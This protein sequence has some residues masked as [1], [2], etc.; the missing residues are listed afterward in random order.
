MKTRTVKI[1][2]LGL[3]SLGISAQQKVSKTKQSISVNKEVTIDLNTSYVEIE[4]ETWNKPTVEIEA[5]LESGELSQDELQKAAKDWNLDID[6]SSDLVSIK[7]VGA[8]A[9]TL[10]GSDDYTVFLKDLEY[11]LAEM[12]AMPKLPKLPNMPELPEMPEFPQLPDLPE[13][14]HS[15]DFDYEAYKRNGEAYLDKWSK[16]YEKTYGKEF[17][18]KMRVW[19][20]KFGESG[21][22]ENMEKWSQEFARRFEGTWSKDME[23]W[24]EEFG[25]SSVRNGAR[26]WNNGE[27]NLERNLR[28][29]WKP[30][31]DVLSGRWNLNPEK[32]IVRRVERKNGS[33]AVKSYPAAPKNEPKLR[34]DAVRP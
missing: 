34:P 22:Q 33:D 21:Y 28:K 26:K 23:K 27:R 14:I 30:G 6:G 29:I 20:K 10:H 4:V 3:I 25:N 9:Y 31:H 5:Y 18:D 24:G 1:I 13:G 19:A 15:I 17:K 12:P 8:R 2:V 32:S 16:E 7:S 11:E